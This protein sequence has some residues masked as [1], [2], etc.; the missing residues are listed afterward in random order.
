MVELAFVKSAYKK[1][2]LKSYYTYFTDVGQ[3]N[4]RNVVKYGMALPM[5][6][7]GAIKKISFGATLLK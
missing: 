5:D 4:T 7:D 6:K 2:M 1:R 3:Q